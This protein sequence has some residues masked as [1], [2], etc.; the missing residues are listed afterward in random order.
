MVISS[1]GGVTWTEE[2]VDI[3]A[4][5]EAYSTTTGITFGN[6]I[7]VSTLGSGD[8]I[9]KSSNG[10]AWEL[11][12]DSSADPLKGYTN[13]LSVS[14]LS[15]KTVIYTGS[16]FIAMGSRAWFTISDANAASWTAAQFGS[17]II[18]NPTN[19][20][21]GLIP[22]V[23]ANGKVVVPVPLDNTGNAAKLM[24]ISTAPITTSSAWTTTDAVFTSSNTVYGIAYGDGKWIAAGTGGTMAVAYGE[25]LD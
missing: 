3:I 4:A 23:Y 11:V 12:A 18:S 15:T 13:S 9:A 20:N 8:K 7:F 6:G 24:H 1:D 21:P 16:Q 22:L 19:H 17:P 2:T 14:D 25:T 10:T 5:A